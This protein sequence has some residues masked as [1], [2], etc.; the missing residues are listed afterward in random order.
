MDAVQNDNQRCAG[1][2]LT[3][4]YLTL[5]RAV[6]LCCSHQSR[7]L[8]SPEG[9]RSDGRRAHELRR[10]EVRLGSLAW[11]A[12]GAGGGGGAAAAQAVDGAA[13][14]SQGNTKVLAFVV[15]PREVSGCTAHR[16]C[17]A[18]AQRCT[19]ERSISCLTPSPLLSHSRPNCVSKLFPIVRP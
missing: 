9:L 14:Y 4:L 8:I 3:V 5:L 15:G 11:S 13:Y 7:E 16:E 6:P 18:N 17:T 19:V 10:V 1:D 2:R 12:S